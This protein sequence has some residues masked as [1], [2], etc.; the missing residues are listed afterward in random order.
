MATIA[1]VSTSSSGSQGNGDSSPLD[2][3]ADGRFVLFSSQATNLVAS[4]PNGAARDLFL[5]D[6]QTGTATLVGPGS[7]QGAVSADG[8]YVAFVTGS[9]AIPADTNGQNDVYLRDLQT[10]TLT[11]LS[12]PGTGSQVPSGGSVVGMSDNGRYVSFTTPL[13]NT[14]GF[15]VVVHDVL[16][17]ERR[18]LQITNE[19]SASRTDVS[20]DGR[21][22][23]WEARESS[24]L[25]GVIYRHDFA[26]GTSMAVSGGEQGSYATPRSGS[27]WDISGDG[28]KIVYNSGYY[29]TATYLGDIDAGTAADLA[30]QIDGRDFRA[31]PNMSSDA[32]F[33]AYTA[34]RQLPGGTQ[35]ADVYLRDLATGTMTLVSEPEGGSPAD[36][37]SGLGVP[38]AV[39]SADGSKVAFSSVATNLVPGD[40]NGAGDVFV[41]TL[42]AADLGRTITGTDGP[43]TLTGGGG[44]DIIIGLAGA[45]VLRGMAGDDVLQG[46]AGDDTL[47]GREGLDTASYEGLT[48]GM[49][50]DLGAG[51][52][53]G[54]Q[55]I[56]TDTLVS[57]ERIV[58]TEAAD[59]IGA[60]PGA[61]VARFEGRG[62]DDQ[63]YA[64]DGADW[65]DGGAG[66]DVI[67]GGAGDDYI[68]GGPGNDTIDGGAGSDTLS[69]AGATT[70][71]TLVMG[72]L[73]PNSGEVFAG[74]PIGMD[75]F[76]NIENVIG[77]EAAD[78]IGGDGAANSFYGMGGDD[79]IFGWTGADT[80]DGGAGNDLLFGQQDDDILRGGDGADR[81]Y[82]WAGNDELWGGA[83]ADAF[84]NT[85][86]GEG[87]DVIRDYSFAGGD[88]IDVP[89]SGAGYSYG[90]YGTDVLVLDAQGQP[91]FR[92]P[93]YTLS[94]ANDV[95]IV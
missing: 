66:H 27:D 78:V 34:L 41:T 49:T 47:D 22:V 24:N 11:C 21:Y 35:V 17:G 12:L 33:I 92:L 64:N 37:T 36:G 15:N 58:G 84:V 76:S 63:L 28:R 77:G 87:I 89:G 2:L 46:G 9:A 65:L 26:T 94:A 72:S 8:R 19:R 30:L 61:A 1:R 16:T 51:Q 73:G 88:V 7:I 62:G 43:E 70:G 82:G 75:R 40:T 18:Q 85:G 80:I 71:M 52:V 86:D 39:V 38:R 32:R 93:F 79:V 83:G 60:A 55:G 4:D 5:K 3:S 67:F 56:G 10:G 25:Y 57:I 45:D 23:F 50:A 91:I 90:Q 69:F 54:G 20:N 59:V 31:V 68:V 6:T 53:F 74:E 81:L 14:V 48:S 44:N 13:Q 95:A 29:N 42:T